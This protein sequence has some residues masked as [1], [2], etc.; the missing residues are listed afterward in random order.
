MKTFK[1]C[2]EDFEWNGRV[3]PTQLNEDARERY[4]AQFL[5]ELESYCV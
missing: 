4:L 5:S 3:H 1:R 2:I